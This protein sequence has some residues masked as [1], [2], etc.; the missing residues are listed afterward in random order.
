MKF[1]PNKID[2]RKPCGAEKYTTPLTW[3]GGC[4]NQKTTQSV[5]VKKNV[6]RMINYASA[7]LGTY[8]P[9]YAFPHA[10]GAI[11]CSPYYAYTCEIGRAHV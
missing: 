10:E 11:D 2:Y 5:T 8:I 4:Y 3:L 9:A 6:T 7:S 1:D